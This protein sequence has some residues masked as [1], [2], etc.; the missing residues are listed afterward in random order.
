MGGPRGGG[1]LSRAA[2]RPGLAS[3][4]LLAGTSM[5]LLTLALLASPSHAQEA[6]VAVPAAAPSAR[7]PMQ[8]GI[9]VRKMLLPARWLDNWLVDASPSGHV[10]PDI[11]AWSWGAEYLVQTP[12]ARWTFYVERLKFN[13]GEGYWD[14]IDDPPD[15]FD[16]HFIV[17][18][19]HFGM[20][21]VGA[22]V[23]QEW[24][25]TDQSK[26]VSL[27]FA[28]GGGLGLGVRTGK[29]EYWGAGANQ[30]ADPVVD[31]DCLP[32][33]A[34]YDRFDAGCESD[35]YEP[36]PP[37]LPLI[38]FN[39]G[40]SVHFGQYVYTRLEGGFHDLPYGGVALGGRF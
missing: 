9:R 10:R 37:V 28:L 39:L 18:D 35:G 2:A 14:D 20:M 40:F 22:N 1:T 7:S 33:S 36:V 26:D 38:D 24:G 34:S 6:A 15:P 19:D 23:G 25:L 8:A 16:G 5:P 29:L 11:K 21:A 31:E 13:V 12:G 17:P 32:D 4:A 30:N 3:R 27:S